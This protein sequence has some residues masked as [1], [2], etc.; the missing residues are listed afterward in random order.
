M[1]EIHFHCLPRVDDGPASWDEAVALCRAA[2]AEGT[3]RIVATPHVLRD[4]W[5]NTNP[6][7]RDRLVR[8]LNERL[9]GT[10][11]ILP[12][13]EYYFSDEV[14]GLAKKGP[15]S[16]LTGLARGHYLLIEFSPGHVPP[17]IVSVFHELRVLGLH[18][19]IAHPERHP[20]FARQPERLAEFVKR[21]AL[22]QIT[23]GSLLGD[24]GKTAQK[25]CEDFFRLGLVHA[26]A[27][28]AHSMSQRPP[29]MAPAHE[30]VRK[31]WGADVARGLFIDNPEAI[32]ASQP[33]PFTGA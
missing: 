10:P 23:A 15:T 11:R 33:V 22:V 13:C 1:I 19:I 6:V 25:A 26:I 9:G 7:A 28:D 30:R 21:G 8:A 18:P 17:L 29:R 12:G 2:A 27:S 32:L 4:K 24:F 20:V 16:P 5:V 14:V 31:K 3:T